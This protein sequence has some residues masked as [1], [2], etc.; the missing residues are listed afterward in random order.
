MRR[1]ATSSHSGLQ[2]DDRAYLVR[3]V[4]ART[5]LAAPE[6]E[7]RVNDVIARASEDIKRARRSAVILAFMLGAAALAGAATAWFA[8]CAGGGHR[9]GRISPHFLLDCGQPGWRA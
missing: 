6:A 8:A 7:R 5:G 2:P 3:L 4:A 9:D 1:T